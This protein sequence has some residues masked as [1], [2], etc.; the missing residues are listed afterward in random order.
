MGQEGKEESHACT[1]RSMKYAHARKGHMASAQ[2]RTPHKPYTTYALR[3]G[4]LPPQ[5]DM[6]AIATPTGTGL[7]SP[8]RL[9]S[10]EA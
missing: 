8:E 5:M 4:L 2:V 3:R 9:V 6:E 1:R 7:P 10:L